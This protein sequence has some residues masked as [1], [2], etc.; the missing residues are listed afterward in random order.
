[1]ATTSGKSSVWQRLLSFFKRKK[2]AAE[3]IPAT[4]PVGSRGS[5]LA[6]VDGTNPGGSIAGRNFSGH[7]FDRMQSQGIPP[8][9]VE[10]TIENGQKYSGKVPGTT[11]HY[12]VVND[13]TVITDT[14]SG[15]VVTV[16][17]GRI[18]Q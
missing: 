17:Y 12:D 7:A 4:T 1:M 15:T 18:K 10:N 11:A 13:V 2:C 9:V 14:A 3:G 16:V 6:V 8:S 5:R